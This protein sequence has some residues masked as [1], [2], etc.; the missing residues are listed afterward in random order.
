MELDAGIAIQIGSIVDDKLG[1]VHKRLAGAAAPKPIRRRFGGSA[2][3][4]AGVVTNIP[5]YPICAEG[6]M[7]EIRK[8][9]IFGGDTHTVVAGTTADIFAGSLQDLSTSDFEGVF[10]SA[11]T[12]PTVKDFG[13]RHITLYA[14]DQ[15][16][17]LV[18]GAA[19][20]QQLVLTGEA[21]EYVL[22]EV[23]SI[24]V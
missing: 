24:H 4:A 22:D 12:V 5:T 21:D 10:L 6:R 11:V 15:V 13:R 9:G 20:N 3:A 18:S 14:M 23:E 19:A 7:W 17:A 8:V 1:P 16:Y 2:V